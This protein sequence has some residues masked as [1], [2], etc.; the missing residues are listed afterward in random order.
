MS[1]VAAAL[2]CFSVKVPS[3]SRTAYLFGSRSPIE[4]NKI[5]SIGFGA[6]APA[7]TCDRT[8]ATVC[9]ISLAVKGS[10][11]WARLEGIVRDEAAET[12]LAMMFD[13]VLAT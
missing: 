9:R 4:L 10:R 6:A 5:F 12:M 11:G 2:I 1:P 13:D 3:Q 7:L 8:A